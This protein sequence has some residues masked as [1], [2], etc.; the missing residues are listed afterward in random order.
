MG[1]L[2]IE[3]F[4][5]ELL[6][7]QDLDPVYVAIQGSNIDAATKRRLCLAYFCFYHLGFAA[8]ASEK[9]GAA[10]W[11]TL[12]IAAVNEKPCKMHHSGRWPRAAER[13]H[14][15]GA[16]ATSA[17]AELQALYGR[18]GPEH[19]FNNVF[20]D[21]P[22]TFSKVAAHVKQHR[23]F[24]DWIAFKVA[25]VGERVLG[26]DVDF[27]DCELGIYKDPRQ[28]AA[29]ARFGDWQH[30]ITD[31]ELRDTVAHYVK[32]FRRFSPPGGGRP[33]NV[34]EVETVMCKYKSHVKG[35][36]PLGKDTREIREGLHGW[37]DLADQLAEKLPRGA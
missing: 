31:D 32:H 18:L 10:F 23:G 8:W 26:Y 29:L 20:G 1:T 25:D 33:V 13:R 28:G 7:T 19:F 22:T 4:G 34:Q 14:F 30:R 37:G 36:Y 35:S 3:E 9:K 21:A 5:S 24:G 11:S 15:R 16:Q 27:S 17:V 2:S 12:S 6:R